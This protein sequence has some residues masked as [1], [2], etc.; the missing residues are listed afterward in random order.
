MRRHHASFLA[1]LLLL[2]SAWLFWSGLY[3]PIL[4]WLGAFSCALSL[5]LAYRI[6]FFSERSGFHLIFRLFRYWVWLLGEIAKSSFDVTK[7]VLQ[8]KL[9]IS[10]TLTRIKSQT[11][12]AVGQVILSNSITLS[13]GTVTLDLDDGELLVHCLTQSGVEAVEK[14]NQMTASLT[15]R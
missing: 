2:V 10:P 15:D 5:L 6:G 8:P 3:K 9:A 11:D 7:I 14:A 13:P 4:L 12:S 1:L